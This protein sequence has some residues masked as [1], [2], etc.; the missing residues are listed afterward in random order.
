MR[1]G[2][3]KESLRFIMPVTFKQWFR[4]ITQYP[5]AYIKFKYLEMKSKRK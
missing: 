5:I 3:Y 4:F 1:K 2:F